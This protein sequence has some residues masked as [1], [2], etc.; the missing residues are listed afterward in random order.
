MIHKLK[1][2]EN[3]MLHM[4][5]KEND[6]LFSSPQTDMLHSCFNEEEFEFITNMI[7]KKLES[8]E[9]HCV[10]QIE[11]LPVQ[12]FLA[13]TDEK[14]FI[15]VSMLKK[16]MED[17]REKEDE[18]DVEAFIAR[19]AKMKEIMEIVKKISYVDSSIL[20][21]GKSGVGKSMI[22][23]LIHKY[24]AR[25]S[26]NFI[27]I[28]CGAIPEALMEAELF[29]YTHGS[30]T[31]G[32]RG[33]KKG[34]FESANEGTVFLD[35]V[36]ELPL[37]LQVKL[38]EVL[39]E[40]CIRPIG[41]TKLIPVNVRVIAATNQN[42]LELVQQKKFRE[43]LYYRLNVVPIEIPPLSERVEDITDLTRHFLKQK[44]N[45][46]GIFKTFHPE[47]EEVFKKYEWPGNVRELENI[48]ER[49]F[50]TTEENEI[51][52]THLPS[53]FH[54]LSE[55]ASSC[56]DKGNDIIPL[57]KAKKM[58]EKELIVRAYD[59]YKSTYKAARALQVDQSTIVKKLKEFRE[60]GR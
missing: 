33:G 22:A 35:E 5:N 14:T 59:L 43:D 51:Q 12:V 34:I 7:K 60:E 44:I 4:V 53:F 27:S 41:E 47:V 42:L 52:L 26:R 10:L 56:Y 58:L 48:I 29:G 1:I 40:N 36:G 17:T 23:K 9:K 25:S 46:Y 20:L 21:L 55:N 2:Q 30:F 45:K 13:R 37:N 24:S 38:L 32:Q 50:I 49:L 57:K 39:Q 3:W 19:S 54:S 11:I 16:Q 6:N 31:G 18:L 28:N 8:M 15:A